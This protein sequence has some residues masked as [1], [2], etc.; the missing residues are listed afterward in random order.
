MMLMPGEDDNMT[1]EALWET[2]PVSYFPS[3]I[4]IYL[5]ISAHLSLY[6]SP[7]LSSAHQEM[8]ICSL[9]FGLLVTRTTG[10]A[11]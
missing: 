8:Q 9:P 3:H 7:F 1:D 4:S 6:I 11:L 5:H 2:L 10:H